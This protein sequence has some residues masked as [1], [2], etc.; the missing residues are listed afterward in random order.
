MVNVLLIAANFAV[1]L[2]YELPNM[3]AAVYH[4]SFYPCSVDN[5]CRTFA[6]PE[7][8]GLSWITAMFLH[9]GWDHILGN[10]LFL[11]IFGNNVEDRMG[12]LRFL[13]FYLVCGYAAG[14]GFALTDPS[15]A[16]P[17]VG[18]SGAIAGVLGAYLVIYPRARVWGLIPILFFLPLRVPAWLMLG[19]WFVLQAFYATGY[20]TAQAGAVAY[21]A[22]VTG[23][24]VGALLG[25]TL[26]R[27]P[28]AP[29]RGR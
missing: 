4:A 15:S 19:M 23:F 12:R 6:A 29:S 25:F 13:L 1:F 7:P 14:Y 22:H 11:A 2:V 3:N 5:S 18:A 20:G 9:G 17:L 24:L 26:R 27:R 10:M 21:A 8:W 28:R 16:Q